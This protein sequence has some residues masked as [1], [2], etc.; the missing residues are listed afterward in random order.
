[1]GFERIGVDPARMGGLPT[2]RGTRVAVGLTDLDIKRSGTKEPGKHQ[3]AWLGL[4]SIREDRRRY[5]R[6]QRIPE[7]AP[8]SPVRNPAAADGRQ[9]GLPRRRHG[10]RAP[11]RSARRRMGAESA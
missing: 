6:L 8:P 3:P 9:P 4:R 5:R 10:Q 7:P 2:I 1:M 11:L